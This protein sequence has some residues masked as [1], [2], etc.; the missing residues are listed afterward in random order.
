MSAVSNRNGP[1]EAERVLRSRS[2]LLACERLLA[3]SSGHFHSCNTL[4][5][6]LESLPLAAFIE[7]CGEIAA[8]NDLA[9][10]FWAAATA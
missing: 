2:P 6:W 3:V 10:R 9:R 7:R 4:H 1:V 5:E 8:A